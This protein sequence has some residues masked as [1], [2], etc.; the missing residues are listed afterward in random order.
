MGEAR[1]L[2]RIAALPHRARVPACSCAGQPSPA[3]DKWPVG[4]LRLAA[5]GGEKLQTLLSV[6]PLSPGPPV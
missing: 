3:S 1:V 5:G 2:L 6:A 4:P